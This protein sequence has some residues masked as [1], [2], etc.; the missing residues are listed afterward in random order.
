MTFTL[1]KKHCSK[2]RK[3][4]RKRSNIYTEAV[5]AIVM[6]C[7]IEIWK[8]TVLMKLVSLV[9]MKQPRLLC[10]HT[11]M[12]IWIRQRF[13]KTLPKHNYILDIDVI[14]NC[15]SKLQS[16]DKREN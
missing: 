2:K 10:F 4:K 15:N 1:V 5:L 11:A 7:V 13:Q 8:I 9:A 16:E 12:G 3:E 6:F 14:Y